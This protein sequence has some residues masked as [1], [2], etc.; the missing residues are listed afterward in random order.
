MKKILS[1]ALV[2]ALAIGFI[3]A[4]GLKAAADVIERGFVSV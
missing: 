3:S 2:G 1:A 4:G